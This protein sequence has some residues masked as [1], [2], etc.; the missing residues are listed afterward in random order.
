MSLTHVE[1]R[2]AC[3]VE[4]R[5]PIEASV[6]PKVKGLWDRIH[7]GPGHEGAARALPEPHAVLEEFVSGDAPRAGEEEVRERTCGPPAP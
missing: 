1:W 7:S 4:Y 2:C 3:G 5:G 6:E